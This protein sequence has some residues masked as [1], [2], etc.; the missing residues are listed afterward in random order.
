[1]SEWEPVSFA[2]NPCLAVWL[3]SCALAE[4][5]ERERWEG[6]EKSRGVEV[7]SAGR[8]H[9]KERSGEGRGSWAQDTSM[10]TRASR[11]ETR[12]TAGPG[13][14]V[15]PLLPPASSPTPFPLLLVYTLTLLTNTTCTQSPL[16]EQETL[17]CV[18]GVYLDEM[19]KLELIAFR[20]WFHS[21]SLNAPAVLCK[22]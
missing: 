12:G 8:G 9:V 6:A 5:K 10:R 4:Y 21:F 1:M 15:S 13:S 3:S 20:F 11:E 2:G 19:T 17:V 22:V 7:Q 18:R 16:T 14:R